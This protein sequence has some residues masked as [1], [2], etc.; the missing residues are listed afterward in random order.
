MLP[1]ACLLNKPHGDVA[2]QVLMQASLDCSPSAS[3]TNLNLESKTTRGHTD[4]ISL[5]RH[6]SPASEDSR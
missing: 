2:H 4:T 5:L 6:L 3:D 1:Q